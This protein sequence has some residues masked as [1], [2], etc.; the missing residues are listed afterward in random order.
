MIKRDLLWPV[1]VVNSTQI[2]ERT[3]VTVNNL[4]P[5]LNALFVLNCVIFR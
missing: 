1:V 3:G 5:G 2:K 4:D